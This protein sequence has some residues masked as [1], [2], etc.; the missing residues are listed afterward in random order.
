MIEPG[1]TSTSSTYSSRFLFRFGIFAI[2]SAVMLLPFVFTADAPASYVAYVLI[3]A[4][5]TISAFGAT[6]LLAFDWSISRAL[7]RRASHSPED[8]G[9]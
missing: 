9:L 5:A 2:A 6:V 3:R 7:A 4:V 1:V 8:P